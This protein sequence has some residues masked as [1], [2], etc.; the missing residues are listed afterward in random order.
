MKNKICKKLSLDLMHLS[1]REYEEIKD[2]EGLKKHLKECADCRKKLKQLIDVDVFTFLA[3]PRSEKFKKGMAELFE[4][5][6]KETRQNKAGKDEVSD[7]T[8]QRPIVDKA[9]EDTVIPK[10]KIISVE[11]LFS[12]DTGTVWETVD[13]HGIINLKDLPT[14]SN[15]SPEVAY[16]AMVLLAQ[17]K[18]LCFVEHKDHVDLFVPK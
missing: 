14:K 11:E 8:E 12:G 1:T 9:C 5:I 7:K 10:G 3:R 6:K 16:G 18:E 2:L 15:L 17:K 13:K 4:R